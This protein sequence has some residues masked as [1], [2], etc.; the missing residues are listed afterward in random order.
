MIVNA[1]EQDVSSG[2]ALADSAADGSATV[3]CCFLVLRD[4]EINQGETT[5]SSGCIEKKLRW[6]SI[7]PNSAGSG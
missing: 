7:L 3:L 2:G 4:V 5:R 6:T 1:H